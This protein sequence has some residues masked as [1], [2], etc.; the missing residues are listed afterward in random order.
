VADLAVTG[1]TG[2][3]GGRVARRLS[4]RGGGLRHTFLRDGRYLDYVPLFV[5]GD[6]VIR[7]PAG[8]GRVAGL[9]PAMRAARMAPT[10]AL[11]TE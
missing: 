4:V 6:G 1:A 9:Y 5:G 11:R 8:D 7:G 3:L 10:E 2:E